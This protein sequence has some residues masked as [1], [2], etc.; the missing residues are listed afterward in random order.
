M[1]PRIHRVHKILIL[2]LL[3]T[4]R[5]FAHY[6]CKKLSNIILIT[7]LKSSKWS[8]PFRF[9]DYNFCTLLISSIWATCAAHFIVLDLVSL[10]IFSEAYEL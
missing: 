4:F 2:S 7:R 8:L 5:N 6:F 10:V 9:S 3:N 1:V